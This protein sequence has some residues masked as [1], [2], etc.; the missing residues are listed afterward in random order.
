MSNLSILLF[1]YILELQYDLQLRDKHIVCCCSLLFPKYITQQIDEVCL[2]LLWITK[3]SS[4]KDPLIFP[5]C[6]NTEMTE[7]SGTLYMSFLFFSASLC[8]NCSV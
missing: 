8:Y 2:W 6:E 5:V 7:E 4:S 1:F 3:V